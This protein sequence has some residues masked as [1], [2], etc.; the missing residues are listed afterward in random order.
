MKRQIGFT[1]I[2]LVVVIVLTSILAVT[3]APKF[4]N[5]GNDA[6]EADLQSLKGTIIDAANIVHSKAILEGKTKQKL[7]RLAD[8]T[9]V[10]FGWPTGTGE[11]ESILNVIDG[12]ETGWKI[13][14]YADVQSE[15]FYLSSNLKR[16][17][18]YET[19]PSWIPPLVEVVDCRHLT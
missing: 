16:C 10:H 9:Q 12:L 6:N 7:T 8:G 14:K 13:N 3:A 17:V 11:G 4:L 18:K 19:E 1:L 5:L 2:E 15:E